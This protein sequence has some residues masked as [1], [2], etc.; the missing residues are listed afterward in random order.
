MKNF[1]LFHTLL[2]MLKTERGNLNK[3]WKILVCLFAFYLGFYFLECDYYTVHEDRRPCQPSS[4][5]MKKMS[6]ERRLSGF[7]QMSDEEIKMSGEAQ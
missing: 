6:G 4:A 1:K 3:I 5:K 2:N 7:N